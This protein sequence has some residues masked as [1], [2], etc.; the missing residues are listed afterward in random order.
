MFRW[1]EHLPNLASLSIET[2]NG[3][4]RPFTKTLSLVSVEIG[5]GLRGRGKL[6]DFFDARSLCAFLYGDPGR[7]SFILSD[8]REDIF[9]DGIGQQSPLVYG[10][11][12]IKQKVGGKRQDVHGST[13][14]RIR[15]RCLVWV[16][17]NRCII[18]DF[19]DP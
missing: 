4:T 1:L 9:L 6:G 13:L 12:W 2:V 16:D 5:W 7:L 3:Y 19:N 15:E 18:P 10:S 8:Q 11:A 17:N 14:Q